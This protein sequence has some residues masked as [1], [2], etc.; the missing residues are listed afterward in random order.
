MKPKAIQNPAKTRQLAWELGSKL[1]GAAIMH[2]QR[3]DKAKTT[4]TLDLA[5]E[6]AAK[7]GLSLAA[8][9]EVTDD[10]QKNTIDCIQYLI[11]N[12][13]RE[14]HNQLTAKYDKSHAALLETAIKS[15]LLTLLY[16]PGDSTT[17]ALASAIKERTPVAELPLEIAAPLLSS[18]G[19]EVDRRNVVMLVLKIAYRRETAA[20]TNGG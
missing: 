15:H 8:L 20:G 12:T 2:S 6:A 7:L 3:A 1:S 19:K 18:V 5:T 13:G 11:A 4:V 16:V 10:K 9:P 14:L 17:D